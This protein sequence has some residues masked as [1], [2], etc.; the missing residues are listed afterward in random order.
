MVLCA[1]FIILKNYHD[2]ILSACKN[3]KTKLK[4]SYV[5]LDLDKVYKM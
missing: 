1:Y 2:S 5:F 4:E 3:K